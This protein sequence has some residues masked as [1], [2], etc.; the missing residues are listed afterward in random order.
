LPP[1]E[2]LL[3][4]ALDALDGRDPTTQ[5]RV[6]NVYIELALVKLRDVTKEIRV[7][8]AR[9]SELFREDQRDPVL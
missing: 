5:V 4:R 9:M 1:L 8:Q 7:L 3:H 6:W 2:L